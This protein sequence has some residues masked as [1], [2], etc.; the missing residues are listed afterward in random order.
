MQEIEITKIGAG[1]TELDALEAIHPGEL[2]RI[3]SAGIERYLDPEHPRRFAEAVDEY[4]TELDEITD[5]IHHQHADA[6]DELRADYDDLVQ[7][8]SRWQDRAEA[9]F[10]RIADHLAA[11]GTPE[12]CPPEMSERPQ[13]P[14]PLFASTRGCF[15]QIAA[16][17]AWQGKGEL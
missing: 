6:I 13:A 11:T 17:R 8:F 12:F 9:V 7:N 4:R 1:A 16:Y 2:G 10:E 5:A 3:V 14:E 15:D